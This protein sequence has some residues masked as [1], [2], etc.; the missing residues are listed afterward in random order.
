MLQMK[1]ISKTFPGV[2][3]LSN[4]SLDLEAG[5]ILAL[6]GE[7]GAGKSTL[8]KILSGA[9][10]L[11]EGEIWIDGEQ[12]TKTSPS[13]MIEKGVAVIYQELMLVPHF[14]VA[15]NLFHGRYPTNKYGKI[16][17]R[18]INE[19][20]ARIMEKLNLPVKPTE[21]VADLSVAKRQMVEIGKALS[22]N[23]KIIVLDEP[24]AVLADSE[25]EGLFKIVRQLS[26]QGISFIYISHRL[27]EIFELCNKLLILKDGCFVEQGAVKDYDT[28]LLIRKMVGRDMSDIYPKRDSEIGEVVLKVDGLTTEGV[29]DHVSLELHRGEILGLAGLAGAGRTETVRA[30]IG[31]DPHDSGSIELFG[32]EVHFK[33]VREALDAGLGIVPEERKTQGLLLKQD[34]L[35]NTTMP[36]LKQF[37]HGTTISPKKELEVTNDFIRLFN[38]RPFNPHIRCENMSGGNQQKVVLAKWI[39]AHCRILL[40]DEPTRGVDVGAKREIYEILNDL[41]AK[42]LSIIMVSSELPE[43]IGTCDRIMVMNEG[44]VTGV[45]NKDQFMEETIMAYATKE[46]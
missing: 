30:I 13:L 43:L 1:N 20:T 36:S 25:L 46:A 16:D 41:I 45:L 4:V 19:D 40:V 33:N 21:R 38:I 23:A 37:S 11:D 10:S 9:Y 5:D 31:A 22:R 34:V 32:K 3:A 12:I 26:E 2:K 14:T 17:Y 8:I 27:K 18:K 35:F 39:A 7:N 42:G 6:A 28:D 15:E 24:T 29:L 44:R